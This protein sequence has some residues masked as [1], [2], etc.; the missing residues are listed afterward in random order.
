[1]S[2]RR[3]RI[4]WGALLAAAA[5]ALMIIPPGEGPPPALAQ[6]VQPATA[7][8]APMLLVLNK[9]EGSLAIVDPAALKVIARVATGEGADGAI[10]QDSR[11]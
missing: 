8:A 5:L 4:A 9:A 6:A 1:M 2:Q 10:L 3:V 11:G 7:K